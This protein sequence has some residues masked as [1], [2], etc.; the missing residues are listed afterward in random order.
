MGRGETGKRATGR[1]RSKDRSRVRSEDRSKHRDEDEKEKEQVRT[2]SS[3]RSL[4]APGHPGSSE[5]PGS[6]D[7]TQAAGLGIATF[8]DI[9]W[10][11]RGMIFGLILAGVGV[12]A[13][14]VNQLTPLY[15]ASARIVVEPSREQ[16]L[17][18]RSVVGGLRPDY[19]TNETE[20]A[21]IGSRELARKAVI[22]LNL[23][24]HPL[25]NPSLRPPRTGLVPTI[26]RNIDTWRTAAATWIMDLTTGGRYSMD[27]EEARALRADAASQRS[28]QEAREA[29]IELATSIYMAY[30]TVQPSQRSRVIT[31]RFSSP[32]PQMAALAANTT[33]DTYI[34][35]QLETRAGATTQAAEW[36]EQRAEELRNRVIASEQRLEAFRR[37]SGIVEVGGASVYARQRAEL[38]SELVS[39]RT[40]RAEVEARYTQVQSMLAAGVGL[41]TVAAVLD[42]QL[43]QRLREQ[44]TQVVRKISELTT[45]LRPDHPRMLLAQNELRDLQEKIASEVGKIVANL[46]NEVEIAQS[47]E[48]NLEREIA[49]I[50]RII[51]QQQEAEV[52]LRALESEVAANNQL[53]RTILSRLQETGVQDQAIMQPDARV[54]TRATVPRNPFYPRTNFMIGAAFVLASIGAVG[55]AILL[56]LLD[57]GFRSIEQL[58]SVTGLPNLGIV[59]LAKKISRRQG[60]VAKLAP[61]E[62]G[63]MFGE[64]IRTLRTGL[65]LSSVDNPPRTVMITSAGPGEGK[66]STSIALGLMAARSGQKVCVVDCDVRHPSVHE[67]MGFENRLGLTDYLSGHA[68]LGDVIELEPRHGLR[69]VSAG[70]PVPN[71]PDLLGSRRMQEL[72][73]KLTDMFDLVILDAP[74][75]LVVSDGLVLARHVDRTAFVVRYEKA[76]RKDVVT[77]I[78]QLA[79]AGA[80]LAGTI[81]TQVNMREGAPYAISKSGYQRYNHYYSKG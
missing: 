1:V 65:L 40:R 71:P 70:H 39:A 75:L 17:D 68:E 6:L 11:R 25:F 26:R 80:I 3:M 21:V 66:T 60:D 38:D 10:R 51:D 12:A 18:L 59:P 30:L 37:E 73:D 35:D 8:V 54:I 69:F 45:Q 19:Y 33:A 57:N 27:L 47:R 63:T 64:A 72:L 53:F 29:A 48:R 74:P 61:D 77:A 13:L 14:Y 4:R 67:Q 58:E 15:S 76:S 78:R 44:E 46:R 34:L 36:L 62:V 9:L 16:V 41:D 23:V 81:F 43:I 7:T 24:E 20:A 2:M 52:T 79:D 22:A 56:E 28:P 42:S 49:R 31:V 55:L 5:E 50:Q 32:D